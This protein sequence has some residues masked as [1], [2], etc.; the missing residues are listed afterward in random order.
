M[1]SYTASF[2]RNSIPRN[3]GLQ[4]GVCRSFP[5]HSVQRPIALCATL[6]MLCTALLNA[7]MEHI[8]K[9]LTMCAPHPRKKKTVNT[10]RC[11]KKGMEK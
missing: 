2:E 8:V 7:L 4:S 11:I 6:V 10:V 3:Q 1:G 9:S 5:S